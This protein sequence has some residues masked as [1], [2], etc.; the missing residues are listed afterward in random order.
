MTEHVTDAD[1][2]YA[3]ERFLGEPPAIRDRSALLSALG[4][5]T[6]TVFGQ[7]AY[8]TLA[9]KAAALTHSLCVNHPLV[10][11]NKRLAWVAAR[12]LFALNGARL[13]PPSDRA[14]ADLILDIAKG[15]RD[16]ESIAAVFGDWSAPS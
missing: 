13:K 1:L 11:G 3:A 12:L 2:L 8:P 14:A 4:R 9:D 7:D 5:P 10:D 16:R 15:E 6:A